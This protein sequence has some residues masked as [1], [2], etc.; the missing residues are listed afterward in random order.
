[1]AT[2]LASLLYGDHGVF[3]LVIGFFAVA[4]LCWR[5]WN[6]TIVPFLH[7]ARPLELPY[8]IPYFGHVRAFFVDYNQAIESARY[9]D[10]R[11]NFTS[12]TNTHLQKT[13]Q[14]QHGT[15]QR[16]AVR[17]TCVHPH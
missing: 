1:M 13:L 6:F 12:L 5:L 15:L 3:V 4:L 10:E 17:C 2:F 8:W 11:S 16:L 14:E 7:P 9:I